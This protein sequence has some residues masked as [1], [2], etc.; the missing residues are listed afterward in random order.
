M[1]AVMVQRQWL[2]LDNVTMVLVKD[3]DATRY[4]PLYVLDLNAGRLS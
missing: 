2:L 4:Q 1:A 3:N